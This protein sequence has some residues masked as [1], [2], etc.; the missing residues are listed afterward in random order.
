MIA[1]PLRAATLYHNQKG[2]VMPHELLQA[3]E[4]HLASPETAFDNRNDWGLVQKRL[5]ITTQKD[6][7]NPT[8]KSFIA[9]N[10]S[11]LLSDEEIIH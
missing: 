9:F 10:T 7:G 6:G 2:A 8:S 5:L 3:M 1:L 4:D 11:A